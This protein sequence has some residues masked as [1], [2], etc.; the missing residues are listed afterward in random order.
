MRARLIGKYELYVNPSPVKINLYTP[1]IFKSCLSYKFWNYFPGTGMMGQRF[2]MQQVM[3]GQYSYPTMQPYMT[4]YPQGIL[5]S[6]S[7]QMQY[8]NYYTSLNPC[9]EPWKPSSSGAP[10]VG[11]RPQHSGSVGEICSLCNQMDQE[12]QRR[13]QHGLC[14]KHKTDNETKIEADEQ[15]R[16]DLNANSGEEYV[17]EKMQQVDCQE[18]AGGQELVQSA[19]IQQ[20]Q[21]GHK[22]NVAE[23][24]IS[25]TATMLKDQTN[26]NKVMCSNVDHEL[27]KWSITD[28]TEYENENIDQS[29]DSCKYEQI[30]I[31][32]PHSKVSQ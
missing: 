19:Y 9:A 2:P 7:S 12:E 23:E 26:E 29:L 31:G 32:N 20:S 3:C 15:C 22:Q 25:S 8:D 6:D 11:V 21:G 24:P 16:N 27:P 28:D 17:N 10:S 30:E 13:R 5:S 18:P 4:Y 14:D 1:L